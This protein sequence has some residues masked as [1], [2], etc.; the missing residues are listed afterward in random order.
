MVSAEGRSHTF[1]MAEM[2]FPRFK[3]QPR[4]YFFKAWRKHRH[5]TQEQLAAMVDMAPASISQIERGL[6]GFKDSTLQA[7][8]YALQCEPGDLLM[9]D[10]TS[11]VW[12][13][14]DTL[15]AMQPDQRQQVIQIIETFKRAA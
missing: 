12:S 14:F 3:P 11:P 6:M 13:I 4:P 7:L 10:P 15:Q 1:S 5:L 2:V 9:R 8:A